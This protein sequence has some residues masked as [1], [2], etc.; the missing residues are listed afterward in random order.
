[1]QL[2]TEDHNIF[3]EQSSYQRRLPSSLA[4]NMNVAE[5]L[6][7][8]V[9]VIYG[10]RVTAVHFVLK[11]RH[12]WCCCLVKRRT[13]P[14][15]VV[16]LDADRWLRRL[17]GLDEFSEC[18]VNINSETVQQLDMHSSVKIKLKRHNKTV[19]K[20]SIDAKTLI[21]GLQNHAKFSSLRLTVNAY[22]TKTENRVHV[23]GVKKK[24]SE[25]PQEPSSSHKTRTNIQGTHPTTTPHSKKPQ[26]QSASHKTRTNVRGMDPTAWKLYNTSAEV[27]L[28]R[29]K[30]KHFLRYLY[31]QE[32]S[33]SLT[34]EQIRQ[35]QIIEDKEWRRIRKEKRE[36]LKALNEALSKEKNKADKDEEPLRIPKVKFNLEN[37]PLP[38]KDRELMY[39]DYHRSKLGMLKQWA[40]RL[41]ELRGDKKALQEEMSSKLD[42]VLIFQS[43]RRPQTHHGQPREMSSILDPLQ[44]LRMN[45][46][47]TRH[48]QPRVSTAIYSDRMFYLVFGF[49]FM[50]ALILFAVFKVEARPVIAL[51]LGIFVCFLLIWK[52]IVPWIWRSDTPEKPNGKR[53]TQKTRRYGKEMHPMEMLCN[54]SRK[55]RAFKQ[56]RK[57]RRE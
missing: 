48:G 21:E 13:T 49:M 57:Q 29:M 39:H 32:C 30:C 53:S 23:T 56:T 24:Q 7:V 37:L 17:Y 36:R 3:G 1:M 41:K 55:K 52:Y 31:C 2:C 4:A 25:E 40:N 5:K 45:S 19:K 15:M 12:T 50:L 10:M 27:L 44:I 46:P 43:N 33:F 28:W 11:T 22:D 54:Q 6:S 47:P 35:M 20:Y 51:L 34:Y 18:R 14:F 9:R 26:E 16:H 42:S 8:S 38:I